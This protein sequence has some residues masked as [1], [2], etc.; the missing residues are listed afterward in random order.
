MDIPLIKKCS[1]ILRF[2]SH[3]KEEMLYDES[4]VIHEHEVREA[5]DSGE[6]IEKYAVKRPYPSFLVYGR[7]CNNRPLHI[8]CAPIVD[9]KILIIITVYQPNP[10]LW[11]NYRRRLQ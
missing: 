1:G 3:A 8:V 5:I 4:G 9:E 11:E 6:I 2:S 7:T 10:K